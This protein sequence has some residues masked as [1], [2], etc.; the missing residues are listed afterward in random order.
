MSATSE[1]NRLYWLTV[2]GARSIWGDRLPDAIHAR[3]E[4]ELATIVAAR[5]AV[6]AYLVVHN[7]VKQLRKSGIAVGLGRGRCVSSI[8]AYAL[9][10][11]GIDPLR[12]GLLM[13]SFVSANRLSPP[14]F[15]LNVGIGGRRKAIDY[16]QGQYGTDGV[17]MPASLNEGRMAHATD[18]LVMDKEAKRCISCKWNDALKCAVAQQGTKE[19]EARGALVINIE[20]SAAITHVQDRL[21]ALGKATSDLGKI[22]LDDPAAIAL[23]ANG[24]TKGFPLFDSDNMKNWLSELKPRRF[25]DIVTAFA[26]YDITRESTMPPHFS[27]AAQSIGATFIARRNDKSLAACRHPIM[28]NALAETNGLVV[29][30]E[31]IMHL[32]HDLAG[33]TFHEAGRLPLA[34]GKRI[35]DAMIEMKKW[36]VV[37]CL[38]NKKFR[39]GKWADAGTARAAAESI[40]QELESAAPWAYSKAHAVSRALLAYQC[41][42]LN[43]AT[44]FLTQRR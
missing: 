32:A 30:Q 21:V 4:H 38:T 26:I 11:T 1:A 2:N 27:V 14:V 37:G 13:E 20:E 16:L 9:G 19:A 28:E 35:L 17:A 23:F 22:P 10:I 33:F 7:M 25:S 8:V 31:Q 40:W 39:V 29:Y 6:T 34:L 18:I 24:E 15:Y 44:D 43:L 36:F 5:D 12:H 3:I 41:A 42:Y